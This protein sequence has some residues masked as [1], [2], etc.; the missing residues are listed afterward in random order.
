MENQGSS[1]CFHRFLGLR[2]ASLRMKICCLREE[3]FNLEKLGFQEIVNPGSFILSSSPTM[4]PDP[5]GI[6]QNH[7]HHPT[8][9]LSGMSITVHGGSFFAVFCG[10]LVE[11]GDNIQLLEGRNVWCC[12]PGEKNREPARLR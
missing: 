3:N 10:G 6:K 8:N 12:S 1:I 4:V 5:L 11:H 9:P 2:I 7:R